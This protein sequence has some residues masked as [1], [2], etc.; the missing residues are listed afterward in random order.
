MKKA[1]AEVQCKAVAATQCDPNELS[2]LTAIN[3]SLGFSLARRTR[4]V[5]AKLSHK[6]LTE[7]VH[8]LPGQ[9]ISRGKA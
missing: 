9:Q 8:L 3:G 5:V 4:L 6:L 7:S 2:S 1:A